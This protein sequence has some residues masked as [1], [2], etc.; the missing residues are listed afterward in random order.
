ML[1]INRSSIPL[2]IYLSYLPPLYQILS[3]TLHEVR[4]E[5]P[6]DKKIETEN[7]ESMKILSDKSLLNGDVA[8]INSKR[9]SIGLIVRDLT[10]S[11]YS[12]YLADSLGLHRME[13]RSHTNQAVSLH[14][15]TPPIEKCYV[16]DQKTGKVVFDPK[17]LRLSNCY[18]DGLHWR[19]SNGGCSM[20][21]IQ[22][23]QYI[24]CTLSL[25]KIS[26]NAFPTHRTLAGRLSLHFEDKK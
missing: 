6:E 20:R 21:K 4:F 24:Q 5:W 9:S 11:H 18:F 10:L 7:V 2:F 14:L 1:K 15:Y 17:A 26:R 19:V 22:C 3:G 13:N 25:N 16:F 12:F 23:I 8:Y